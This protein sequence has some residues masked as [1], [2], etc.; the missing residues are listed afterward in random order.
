[1]TKKVCLGNIGTRY[2]YK[3]WTVII[4]AACRT[5]FIFQFFHVQLRDCSVSSSAYHTDHR[6][7]P[8]SINF[9]SVY[10]CASEAT[11]RQW[12]DINVIILL[13]FSLPTFSRLVL[14]WRTS[15]VFYNIY[16]L[17]NELR[18]GLLLLFSLFSAT[19]RIYKSQYYIRINTT[20]L[21]S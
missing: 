9:I 15:Y 3:K 21:K 17:S 8:A 20:F 4:V 2:Y 18:V 10:V 6:A 19:L 16:M 14:P 12:T 1:M 11:Q 7:H 5:L 13:L